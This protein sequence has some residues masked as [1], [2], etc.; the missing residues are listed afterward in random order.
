MRKLLKSFALVMSVAMCFAML[1]AFTPL[2]AY[3]NDGV[4]LPNEGDE[5]V[6]IQVLIEI[7]DTKTNEV[8]RHELFDVT[9]STEELAEEGEYIGV[10]PFSVI[11]QNLLIFPYPGL[12]SAAVGSSVIFGSP[13]VSV[14]YESGSVSLVRFH[15]HSTT[16]NTFLG[17]GFL[18]PGQIGHVT[19]TGAT[20][21]FNV[22]I[23][24]ALNAS[25]FPFG[26]GNS[27]GR[28][29]VTW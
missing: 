2:T 11:N 21:G 22:M 20:L 6:D 23:G 3:A 15:V 13:R 28:F 18:A 8:V 19:I 12:M 14:A 27:S 5:Y 26:G 4:V 10:Q 1:P 24:G 17:E 16:L 7:V 9:V 25:G 29:S